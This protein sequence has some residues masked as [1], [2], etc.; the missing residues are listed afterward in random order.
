MNQKQEKVLMN[1]LLNIDCLKKLD[2]W[3]NKFNIFDVL[4]ITNAEI[5]HSNIL[6]WLLDPNGSH[7]LGD[8]FL[9]AFINNIVKKKDSFGNE[10]LDLLLQDFYSYRVLREY[11]HMD[12]VLVSRQEK[13]CYV[14]EN[15]IW[16]GESRHQL[17]DCFKKSQE[18]YVGYRIIYA[19]LTP[20]GHDASDT[21][22]WVSISYEEIIPLLEDVMKNT[23]TS[24]EVKFFIN[25][26]IKAVRENIMGEKDEKLIDICNEIY[27]MHREALNL[28]FQNVNLD[29]TIESEIICKVLREY[30][31][32]NKIIYY[33]D[34]T[35]RFFTKRMTEYLPALEKE[36]SSWGTK[37]IYYYW[38]EKS[39]NKLIVHAE[40]GGWG[41]PDQSDSFKRMKLLIDYSKQLGNKVSPVIPFR[42]KRIYMKSLSIN[43]EDYEN[44]IEK[45]ARKLI[46]LLLENEDKLFCLINNTK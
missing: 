37:W 28:I 26:Y 39:N 19:F 5:R 30:S 33:N 6:G 44:S 35:W 1:F 43:E 45:Q 2:E 36:E 16:S 22:N 41:V 18:E 13:T 23:N 42:Y 31:K 27:N 21:N 14:I 11:N 15:K 25:N 3:T 20:D 17:Q 12:L 32:D 9:K 4:K 29:K 8:S 38:L 34:N 46:D 10:S 24:N 40:L 7:K